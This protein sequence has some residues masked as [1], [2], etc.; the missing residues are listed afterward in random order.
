MLSLFICVTDN[1]TYGIPTANHTSTLNP[2]RDTLHQSMPYHVILY[3]NQS[4]HAL[5]S[6]IMPM[7]IMPSYQILRVLITINHLIFN[8]IFYQFNCNNYFMCWIQ[9]CPNVISIFEWFQ[10]SV[11]EI[12]IGCDHFLSSQNGVS[13][14]LQTGVCDQALCYLFWPKVWWSFQ[15][16]WTHIPCVIASN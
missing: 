8:Q 7:D 10:Y 2:H 9:Y 4:M 16:I 5:Q 3:H 12:S 1:C 6:Q 13:I 15:W 11:D 14:S